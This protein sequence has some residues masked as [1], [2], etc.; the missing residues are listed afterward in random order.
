MRQ[1]TIA[2][3]LMI[4]AGCGTSSGSGSGGILD[5][6]STLPDA[7]GNGFPDIPAPEGVEETET[8]PLQLVNQITMS[9]AERLAQVNLPDLVQN[10]ISVRAR[11]LVNLTY[12]GDI[13]DR[14]TGTRAVAPFEIKAE[15]ICPLTIEV[16]VTVVADIPVIGQQTVQSF[17]PFQFERDALTNGYEC[18]SII[19]I[20]VFVNED[21]DPS[22][23]TDVQ[24]MPA[25]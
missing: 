24:P 15:V 23:T 22:T 19:S 25:S 7:N 10:N 9:Q 12:P 14:L 16:R 21:G 1:M 13:T 11:I 3:L 2:V 18:G 4:L 5:R 8:V 17:G 6:L 20:E